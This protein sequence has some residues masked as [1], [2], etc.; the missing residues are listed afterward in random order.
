MVLVFAL[1][2][3]VFF[4]SEKV[5]AAPGKASFTC[6]PHF[7]Q[8]HYGVR[9]PPQKM[10]PQQNKYP[11]H[12]YHTMNITLTIQDPS[13]VDDAV[14]RDTMYCDCGRET[15]KCT[16]RASYDPPSGRT[17]RWIKGP[18][19]L[20]AGGGNDSSSPVNFVYRLDKVE[21]YDLTAGISAN[22]S[23]VLPGGVITWT[24]KATRS[25]SGTP[26]DDIQGR[27]GTQR[28]GPMSSDNGVNDTKTRLRKSD[29]NVLN[30]GLSE[31]ILVEG[32]V[33]E[34]GT[35][36]VKSP[37]PYRDVS[38]TVYGKNTV[39]ST[40]Q[41]TSTLL[42]GEDTPENTQFCRRT[43]I[44]KASF[45]GTASYSS[46][47]SGYA[48]VTVKTD[49]STRYSLVPRVD[50]PSDRIYESGSTVTVGSSV[51]N[52]G[53][54]QSRPTQWQ[55][56]RMLLPPGINLGAN[57][58]G[59]DSSADACGTYFRPA[60]ATGGSCAVIA[61]GNNKVFSQV[62]V[63]EQLQELTSQ[64]DDKPIGTRFC[65]ALSIKPPTNES[66]SDGTWRHSKIECVKVGK[67]PKV[68]VQ[69]GDL[70]VG[71][72]FSGQTPIASLASVVNTSS[73]VRSDK[74]YGSWVEYGIRAPGAIINTG[75]ASGL[76]GGSVASGQ[77]N[78]S[79]LTFANT[80]KFGEFGAAG[81]T[82]PDVTSAVKAI[83]DVNS[84]PTISGVVQLSAD[85]RGVRSATGDIA[86]SSYEL[87]PGQTVVIYAPERTVTIAGNITYSS[88]V[89]SNTKDIPQLVIISN[90]IK[91]APDVDRV[92]AWLV[93]QG[94]E[95]RIDTCADVT[96]LS[97]SLCNKQLTVNGP[98]A[99]KQLLLKRT[100]GS[101]PTDDAS[102]AAPAEIFN[103]RADAFLWA[104]S[105]DSDRRRAITTHVNELPPRF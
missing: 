33:R 70:V 32:G 30:S 81:S 56:T 19:D 14:F 6:T 21:G 69:G 63:A 13:G 97:A 102:R 34:S 20:S 11:G 3:S 51:T 26:L 91:I 72:V 27:S 36:S 43:I 83:Y 74:T 12:K 46:D 68:Q 89:I 55:M 22:K 9:C 47:A 96:G 88:G 17:G 15:E 45:N 35:S 76:S 52:Q 10:H 60:A 95:G 49:A 5:G 73:V 94:P 48:C 75:S 86:L 99:A 62:N 7:K 87:V 66:S 37:W 105:V 79:K 100:A 104:Q 59:G 50:V 71:S 82:I 85:V 64:L 16:I 78:W 92:D 31:T 8:G 90:S 40:S 77:S 53:P 1:S 58:G 61:Q 65:F 23:T 38:G 98:V 24:H 67:R 54:A 39:A 29:D 103:L 93:A 80:P 57:E 41:F 44:D 18:N 101:E 42:V 4:P 2:G 84:A 28:K 25:G